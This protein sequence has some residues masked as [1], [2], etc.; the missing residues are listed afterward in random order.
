[1]SQLKSYLKDNLFLL[2]NKKGMT[3]DELANAAKKY[4][5]EMTRSTVASI[6]TRDKPNATTD[7]IRAIALARVLDVSVEDLVLNQAEFKYG[8]GIASLL[9]V[10]QVR[11]ESPESQRATIPFYKEFSGSQGDGSYAPLTESQIVNF[12]V[13]Q[14]FLADLPANTGTHNLK[15]VIG[16]GHSMEPMFGHG[17]LL[18]VDTGVKS[19]QG[20]GVYFFRIG[21][22]YYIKIL[23]VTPGGIRA[24]SKNEDYSSWTITDDKSVQILARVLRVWEG[25]EPV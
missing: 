6:E 4:C 25:K 22:H 14:R 5:P 13:S 10:D 8:K 9:G 17:D 11:E 23:E 2:R 19:V 3:Q 15:I 18:I 24:V 7:V 12:E 1:M 21:D 20:D 16:N